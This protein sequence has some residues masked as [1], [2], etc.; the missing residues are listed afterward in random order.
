MKFICIVFLMTGL[1]GNTQN[2][3]NLAL[4]KTDKPKIISGNKEVEFRSLCLNQSLDAP[5]KN[6]YG[7]VINESVGKVE[8]TVIKKNG[9][10]K[11]YHSLKSALAKNIIVLE[12]KNSLAVNFK[13][14]PKNASWISKVKVDIKE[15]ISI[16]VDEESI[17]QDVFD[18][19]LKNF[20]ELLKESNKDENQQNKLWD[21]SFLKTR[22][23]FDKS[24]D[25]DK[26]LLEFQKDNSTQRRPFEIIRHITEVKN[27]VKIDQKLKNR[28][29]NINF[30]LEDDGAKINIENSNEYIDVLDYLFKNCNPLEFCINS[31]LNVSA[32][33]N[34]G[35]LYSETSDISMEISSTG[36]FVL[37]SSVGD[38]QSIIINPQET[39]IEIKQQFVGKR[40]RKEFNKYENLLNDF[41]RGENLETSFNFS[42]PS[43]FLYAYAE[44]RNNNSGMNN[45]CKTIATLC[46]SKKH[47]IS[48]SVTCGEGTLKVSTSG[49]ISVSSGNGEASITF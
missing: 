1:L 44:T 35:C 47:S 29:G 49:T 13:I 22:G 46:L 20:P 14:H 17:N 37:S 38:G 25:Y 9:E 24:V 23:Y 36:E 40:E 3:Q 34:L 8:I 4:L 2:L 6:K 33:M 19:I 31:D 27:I 43:D 18:F 7:H 21:I 45:E 15:S 32:T 5:N 28:K 11:V 16:A 42:N 41:R 48:F 39:L 10:I 30:T 12:A 26:A